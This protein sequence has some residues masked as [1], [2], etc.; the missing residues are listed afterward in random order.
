VAAAAGGM[1]DSSSKLSSIGI[2]PNNVAGGP[3]GSLATVTT[4]T[5]AGPPSYR[6]AKKLR[7]KAVPASYT[8]GSGSANKSASFTH[9]PEGELV[10]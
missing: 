7:Q 8:S 5:A 6:A 2:M 1:A 4:M 10:G 3:F 9:L